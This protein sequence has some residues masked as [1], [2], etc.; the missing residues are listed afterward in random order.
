M[1]K[2]CRT[3]D[4]LIDALLALK[5]QGAEGSVEIGYV[6]NGDFAENGGWM[7]PCPQLSGDGSN[8]CL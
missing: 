5:E 3:L 1:L 8:I 2:E 6:D 4:E 7:Y